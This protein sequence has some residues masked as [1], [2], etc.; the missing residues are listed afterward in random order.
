MPERAPRMTASEPGDLRLT[1]AADGESIRAALAML[2]AHLAGAELRPT[3]AP[4][5]SLCWPRC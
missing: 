1:L 4:R 5:P 2:A 3:I